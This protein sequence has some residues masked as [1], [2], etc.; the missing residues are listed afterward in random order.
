MGHGRPRPHP[1]TGSLSG[2]SQPLISS[3]PPVKSTQVNINQV[4]LAQGHDNPSFHRK[5]PQGE[6]EPGVDGSSQVIDVTL[7]IWIQRNLLVHKK[8]RAPGAA[9]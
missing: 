6:Q 5:D 2:R 7:V 3:I 4:N 9:G 1:S 8:G